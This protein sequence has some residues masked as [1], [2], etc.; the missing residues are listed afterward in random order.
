VREGFFPPEGKDPLRRQRRQQDAEKISPRARSRKPRATVQGF[1]VRSHPRERMIGPLW[2]YLSPTRANAATPIGGVPFRPLPFSQPSSNCGSC[3]CNSRQRRMPRR[4]SSAFGAS[5][6]GIV[7][8]S[9]NG[10]LGSGA[11][12]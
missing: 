8:T 7:S 12:P 10:Y 3:N 2:R 6:I 5:K 4:V 1:H 9:Q 11:S